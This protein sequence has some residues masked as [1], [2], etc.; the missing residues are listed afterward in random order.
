MERYARRENIALYPRLLAETNLTKDQVRRAELM[1]LLP[2]E[3]AKDVK[4]P[5]S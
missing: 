4:P 3:I 5:D 1:R 2:A